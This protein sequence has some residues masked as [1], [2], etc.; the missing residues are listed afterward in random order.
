MQNLPNPFKQ[1]TT[2]N[3]FLSEAGQATLTITDITGSVVKTIQG[4]YQKGM[5]RVE[6]SKDELTS[7][8][9]YYYTLS[10]GSFVSTRKMV[11]I[12]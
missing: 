12:E 7:G 3:F 5:H 1:A 6:I 11:L 4:N 2:L 9:V 10:S 8:G